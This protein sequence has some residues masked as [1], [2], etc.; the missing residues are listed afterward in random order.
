MNENKR[1]FMIFGVIVAVVAIILL[2]SFWPKPDKSFTCGIKSDGEYKKLGKV[3]F[4]Q[5]QCLYKSDTKNPLVVVND[6]NDKDKKE[7]NDM[8]KKIGHVI[9][10]LDINK[11]S[12]DDLK[13]IKKELKYSGKS[14]KKDVILTV[15]N[16]KVVDYKEDF[17]ENTDDFYKFLKDAKLAKFACGVVASDEYENLGEITYDQYQCLYDSEEPFALMLAQT[18]CSYCVAFKPIIN[19]YVVEKKIPVYVLEIDQLSDENRNALL[20]SLSYFN[21]NSEWGTPLTLGIKNK[22]V[23]SELS[24]YTEDESSLEDFFNKLGLK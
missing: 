10:Y 19:N 22:E 15:K 23:I 14:F 13:N 6:L 12:G 4:K 9:Y 7:L 5:Y 21:D 2:I 20:S 3:N 11:I 8:A 24:G 1:L 16:E 18:T 17:L